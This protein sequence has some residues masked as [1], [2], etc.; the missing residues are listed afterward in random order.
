MDGDDREA[1]AIRLAV[2][3]DGERAGA[4][5]AAAD[6][7]GANNEKAIG[8]EHLAGAN[9]IVP[10]AGRLGGVVGVIAGDMGVTAESVA[11]EDGVAAVGV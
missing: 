10:P 9:G 2:R 7:V 3:G 11:D 5:P 4:A 8:I 6:H 1:Q